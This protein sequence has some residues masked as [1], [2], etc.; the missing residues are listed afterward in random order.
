[1]LGFDGG[2]GKGEDVSVVFAEED[3][4]NTSEAWTLI[5]SESTTLLLSI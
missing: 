4:D 1:M 5:P 3:I 2:K